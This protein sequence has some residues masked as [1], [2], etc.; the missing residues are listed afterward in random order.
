MVEWKWRY[1]KVAED[2]IAVLRLLLAIC[3]EE[4]TGEVVVMASCTLFVRM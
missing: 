3:M 1:E 2:P 4:E